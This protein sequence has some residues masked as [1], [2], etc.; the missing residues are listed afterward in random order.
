VPA[1]PPQLIPGFLARCAAEAPGLD[2]VVTA[3]RS[4]SSASEALESG[5]DVALVR[6]NV[7]DAKVESVVAAREPVGVALPR[8]HPLAHEGALRAEQLS[9]V[10]LIGFARATDPVENDRIFDALRAA[11][12]PEVELVHESHPGAVESS[13]RLVAQGTGASLKLRSEVEAF[14]AHEVTWRPLQG[15]P[16]EVVISAA[17]RPDRVTPALERVLPLVTSGSPSVTGT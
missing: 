9:G 1:L 13:L 14:G 15:V 4:G 2:V 17:W 12:L 6:G 11:G 5:V 3:L 7:A 16:L 10:P 8:D